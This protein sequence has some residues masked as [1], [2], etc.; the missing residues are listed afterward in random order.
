MNSTFTEEFS[1]SCQAIGP[2][3][4]VASTTAAIITAL[5][6]LEIESISQAVFKA[7][8]VGAGCSATG[9]VILFFVF[10]IYFWSRKSGGNLK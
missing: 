5:R 1:K 2:Y 10:A 7:I 8:L 4:A 9:L 3:I 6:L